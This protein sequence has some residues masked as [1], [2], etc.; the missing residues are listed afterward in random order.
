MV[1]EFILYGGAFLSFIFTLHLF[2]YNYGN[3]L[4]N[5]LLGLLFFVRALNGSILMVN[6]VEFFEDQTKITLLIQG[7]LFLAPATL[8]LYIR[9]YLFDESRLKKSDLLHLLPFA[10][11]LV[12][13]Y[14]L[15]AKFNTSPSNHVL[16]QQ[17]ITI[18]FMVQRTLLFSI[19]IIFCWR[20]LLTMLRSDDHKVNKTS[21]KWLFLLLVLISLSQVFQLFFS[22]FYLL[23][24]IALPLQFNS[25]PFFVI[26][27]LA[28]TF[29]I[30]FILRNP[31]VLY[32]NL[33][34]RLRIEPNNSLSTLSQLPNG[35]LDKTSLPGDLLEFEQIGWYLQLIENHMKEALPFLDPSFTIGQLSEKLAIPVHH[36]SFVLNQGLRKNF[37][38]Y[39]N[40]YRVE[41][42]IQEYP[43]RIANQTLESIANISGFKSSSTFY[44]SFKKETGTS[45]TAYFS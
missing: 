1:A 44:A 24:F 26:S 27:G 34:P 17:Q 31:K 2:T 35:Q 29:F 38:E 9:A 25:T 41:Y 4:L 43:L 13:S 32:G 37:R 21:V 33:I 16:N 19:Y 12:F 22:S 14:L 3:I 39:I 8:F 23:D 11:L 7:L 20:L 42:F 18:V 10:V 40:K 28:S 15:F 36:C 6:S 45:P 5:R 30:I